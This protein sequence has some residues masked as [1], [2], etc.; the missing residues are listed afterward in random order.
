VAADRRAGSWWTDRDRFSSAAPD[1]TQRFGADVGVGVPGATRRFELWRHDGWAALG[2]EQEARKQFLPGGIYGLW[3]PLGMGAG[4]HEFARTAGNARVDCRRNDWAAHANRTGGPGP[5]GIV[6]RES[7]RVASEHCRGGA[8]SGRGKQF[9]T[10]S[11]R[12]FPRARA[13]PSG[14]CRASQ[15]S[16]VPMA[17]L[18]PG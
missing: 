10:S 17:T 15:R 14:F 16:T 2:D 13:L 11:I 1:V 4:V 9:L 3:R 5:A 8:P 6:E 18:S 7:R 12:C